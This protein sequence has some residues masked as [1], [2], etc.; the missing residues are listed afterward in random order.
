ME[1]QEQRNRYIHVHVISAESGRVMRSASADGADGGRVVVAPASGGTFD[2]WTIEPAA[3]GAAVSDRWLLSN[4]AS[5][6][7]TVLAV[8]PRDEQGAC[9]VRLETRGGTPTANQLWFFEHYH[10]QPTMPRWLPML[11][12]T[13]RLWC[14]P[15]GGEPVVLTF[16][17]RWPTDQDPDP[18]PE[19]VARPSP[20]E[21]AT[22]HWLPIKLAGEE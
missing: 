10:P 21:G 22:S 3:F 11:P 14:M 17:A 15:D 16:D 13:M 8:G 19:L 5:N 7:R 12:A 20:D 9:A 2:R 18:H 4:A 6:R 1:K